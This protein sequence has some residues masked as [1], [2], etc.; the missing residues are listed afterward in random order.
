M[1]C[2]EIGKSRGDWEMK[3]RIQW[4]GL[5]FALSTLFLS[6]ISGCQTH[7]AGMTLPS[8]HY[9]EHPPQ[10]V[11]PSPVFPLSKEL[12]SMEGST[13]QSSTAGPAQSLPAPLPGPGGMPNK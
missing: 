11:P 6:A 12:A 7:V 8:G 10:Y 2:H 4:M 9:L 3:K 1:D 5:S 13:N